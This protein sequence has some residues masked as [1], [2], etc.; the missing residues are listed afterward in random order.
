MLCRHYYIAALCGRLYT[1]LL[2][3]LLDFHEP[4]R[5]TKERDYN[6][7]RLWISREDGIFRYS[8]QV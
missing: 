4:L 3:Q 5:Y 8:G 2:W 1:T 6:W 7:K